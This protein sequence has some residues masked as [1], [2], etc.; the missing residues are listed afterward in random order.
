MADEAAPANTEQSEL[1]SILSL[2]LDD[3]AKVSAKEKK[4][5]KAE[6]ASETKGKGK[7]K[8]NAKGK[9]KGNA[10]GKTK[11]NAKSPAKAASG[12]KSAAKAPPK[13]ASPY[14]KQQNGSKVVHVGNLHRNTVWQDLKEICTENKLRCER[15]EILTF[16]NGTLSGFG[17][18]TFSNAKDAKAAVGKLNNKSLRGNNI[19]ASLALVPKA[20]ATKAKAKATASAGKGKGASKANNGRQ[21]QH[22][23]FVGNLDKKVTDGDLKSRFSNFGEVLASAVQKKPNGASKGFGLVSFRKKAALKSALEA[24]GKKF[25]GRDMRLREDDG[26]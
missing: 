18:I 11:G 13:R 20:K 16:E 14:T 6:A 10:K 2:S 17:V 15:A 26:R 25:M 19:T 24:N 21:G 7:A 5:Q 9:A 22:V 8:G 4:Q 23:L 12:K 1:G 3:L